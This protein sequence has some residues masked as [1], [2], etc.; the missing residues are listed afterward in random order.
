MLIGLAGW[1]H[2][3]QSADA[4]A[5]HE[6]LLQIQRY[7]IE[8]VQNE[9]VARPP[10]GIHAVVI[11]FFPPP[12]GLSIHGGRHGEFFD[13]RTHLL[14]LTQLAQRVDEPAQLATAIAVLVDHAPALNIERVEAI[15][16]EEI[17]GHGARAQSL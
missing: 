13:R 5:D 14:L 12:G 17:L 9:Q 11:D 3:A 10:G 8:I 4:R 16:G 6:L 15:G 7:P 2:E 1:V